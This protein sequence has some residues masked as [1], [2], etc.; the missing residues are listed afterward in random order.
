MKTMLAA[1]ITLVG[2]GL[3]AE[4]FWSYVQLRRAIVRARPL[5]PSLPE[6]PSVSVI[7]PVRGRD[8]GAE[9]NIAAALDTGYPGAVETI[10]VFDDAR[11]SAYP[12]VRAA[13]D[14]H[15]AAGRRGGVSILLAGPPPPGRTGKLNAMMVG[16]HAARG[17]LI[18]FADSDTRPDGDVLRTIVDALRAT[19]SAGSA[20]APVV[21]ANPLSTAGDVGYAL[22]LNAL[23]GPRVAAAAAE[24]DGALP[25]IM[26]QY[27]VLRREAIEAI[28]GLACADGQLVDDMFIGRC[29]A[30]LG[31]RNV[32]SSH[33]MSISTG[34]MS[35]EDFLRL[36]HRWIA[37]SRSGLPASF[38]WP[39][40]VRGIEFWAAMAACA[41]ALLHGHVWAAA[42]P[43]AAM[44][45][46]C[47]SLVA[48]HHAF[49]GALVPRRY[50]WL[51]FAI[52]VLGPAVFLA[53]VL[54]RRVAWR[55]RAYELDPAARLA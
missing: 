21:V 30:D 5:R 48:L 16:L 4:I 49:G 6:Y 47:A 42:T 24:E 41:V 3:L 53:T 50:W 22:L 45:S 46:F 55:G 26:G 7:R 43:A 14:A 54:Y 44:V 38:T 32:M 11:D 40:W 36:F 1:V 51:P 37:F 23:Y 33:P 17:E 34:N 52:F 9:E 31:Y 8:V 15:R 39:Q 35:W 29:M 28:G 2:L 27:M 25:F 13:V 20:F 19:P 10:F 12:L 18:A